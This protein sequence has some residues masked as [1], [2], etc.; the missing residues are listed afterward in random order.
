MEEL[1]TSET[2][3]QMAYIFKTKDLFKFFLIKKIKE[4]YWNFKSW[5]N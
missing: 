1:I 3:I 5:K 4:D 2:K